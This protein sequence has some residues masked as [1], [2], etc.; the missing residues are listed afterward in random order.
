[1]A[2]VYR[3]AIIAAPPAEVWAVIRDF[4]ALDKWAPFIVQS[5]IEQN[6]PS[7]KVGCVR[8]LTTRAGGVV[9]ERLLA[10][11]DF[12]L[13]QTYAIIESGMGVENYV[14]TLSLTPVTTTN[15]TFAEWRAEFDAALDREAAIV[16]DIGTNV[17]AAG[18]ASLAARWRR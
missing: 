18:L 2:K 9:R 6:H 3:S 15:G 8:N 14:A 13:S 1:M 7:D 10:L 17:F 5:R 12:D 16:E 11:S 4:N